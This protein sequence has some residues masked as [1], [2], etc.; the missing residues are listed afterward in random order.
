MTVV[1]PA[2]VSDL[3]SIVEIYNQSV[4]GSVATFDVD[5]VTVEGRAQW[6]AQFD[7]VNPMFVAELDGSVKASAYYLP[8]RAKAAYALT[9]EVTVY[10]DAAAHHR[11]IASTLY[12]HL[13][14]H[15]R[16]HGVHA[17]VGVLGGE[18]PASA[19]LHAKHGF[20]LVGRLR[21]VGRKFD[22]YVD[23]FY[24]ELILD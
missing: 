6:F 16:Q 23:T 5:P 7:A 18:N 1:R 13:I 10:V 15:A 12:E 21:E 24:F 9:K 3:P 17:L 19:A 11:G 8:F 4:T 14:T 22:R 20:E 2:S